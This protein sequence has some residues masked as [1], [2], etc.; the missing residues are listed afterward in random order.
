MNE[1]WRKNWREWRREDRGGISIVRSREWQTLCHLCVYNP[2]I[3]LSGPFFPVNSKLACPIVHSHF[4]LDCNKHLTVNMSKIELLNFLHSP[5][6]LR[7]RTLIPPGTQLPNTWSLALPP[8]SYASSNPVGS[9][10]AT[11]K[12]DLFPLS[13]LATLLVQTIFSCLHQCDD[14]LNAVVASLYV[15]L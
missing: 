6:Y 7:W 8:P 3:Y 9:P 14:F 4:S 10:L 11:S 15:L 2:H 1:S 12:S 5:L 13:L